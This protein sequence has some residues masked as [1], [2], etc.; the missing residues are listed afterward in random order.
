MDPHTLDDDA[1]LAALGEALATARHPDTDLIIAQGQEAFAFASVGD[2]FALLVY[3]S[4]L[5]NELAGASRAAPD[6]RTVIF[7]SDAVSVEVE[8]AAD[9]IV[10]QVAP[11]G[12][13]AVVA[14]FSDGR[15]VEAEAD[16]LGCFTLPASGPGA[17]R[18]R[19]TRDDTTTVTDWA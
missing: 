14:E 13:A 1:L 12:P 8:I 2:E 15:Q 11:P 10:G 7:E 17:I 9:S 5:E 19:V 16:D 4:L 3:D 6:S 18:F